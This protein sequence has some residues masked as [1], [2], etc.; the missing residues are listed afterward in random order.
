MKKTLKITFTLKNTYRVNGIIYSLKQIPVIRKLLPQ[1]LYRSH[2]LKT[3]AGVLSILWEIISTFAGKLIYLLLMINLVSSLYRGIPENGLFGLSAG[4]SLPVCLMLPFAIAG[5]KISVSALSLSVYEKTGV[6][7]SRIRKYLWLYSLIL[8]GVAYGLPALGF[9]IPSVIS[10]IVMAAFIPAGICGM[11]KILSFNRYDG[12]CRSELFEMFNQIDEAVNDV[13]ITGEKSISDD[14]DSVSD[15]KGF[16]YLNDLF[17]K[18]HKKILWTAT[19]R[20]SVICAAVILVG[21]VLCLISP[22]WSG[23]LNEIMLTW[24]PYFFFIMYFINRGNSFTS[25]LFMNCDHSLLTYSCFKKPSYILKLFCIRLR[26][27]IKINI[28]PA[29]I[30]GAGLALILYVSG[31]TDNYLNYVV[32]SVSIPC[33]SVF[34]STHYLMLYYLFQPY[35]AGTEMKSG[36]YQIMQTLTYIACF[37][38]MKL[39]MP[40]LTFGIMTIVFCI[41]Y[42]IIACILIYKLAPKTFRLRN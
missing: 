22:E 17:I 5:V 40:T 41:L 16:E 20:I 37:L 38:L 4:V 35:N 8:L 27:I 34:F 25:A 24:L 15:K 21:V 42:S 1:S 18:R 14:T 26:E 33:I 28:V 30:L 36:T 19:R 13:R 9:T 12:I 39:R 31:G 11:K 23:E 2:G 29:L 6:Y 10:V 32:L 7:K 3:F